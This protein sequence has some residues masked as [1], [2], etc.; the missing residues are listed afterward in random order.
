MLASALA[1]L[2]KALKGN[3]GKVNPDLFG[4]L[5]HELKTSPSI[6]R[7][8]DVLAGRNPSARLEDLIGKS[9]PGVENSV[10][11][12]RR[13]LDALFALMQRVARAVTETKVISRAEAGCFSWYFREI[14]KHPMLSDYFYSSGFLDLWDFAQSWGEKAEMEI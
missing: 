3:P 14:Q 4:A 5:A 9:F 11:D 2:W 7:A 6:Q 1:A 12:T 10:S 13:D 8:T